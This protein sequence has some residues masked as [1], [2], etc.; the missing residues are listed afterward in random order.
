[1]NLSEKILAAAFELRED[2]PVMVDA[3]SVSKV[4]RIENLLDRVDI[5]KLNRLE[6][7][8]LTGITLDTKERVKHAGYQLV[9]RG[10]KRVFI[11]MGMAGVCAV[12]NKTAL[13]IPAL[14]IAVKD[15]TGAGDAFAAGI[16]LRLNKDLRAQ[17]ESGVTLAAEHLRR[18]GGV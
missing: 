4:Q 13:F 11:T 7:E 15:V 6:A 17:A 10:V 18:K 12:E 8:R 5:L 2:K 3:V 9:N 1:M 14:P 16:A